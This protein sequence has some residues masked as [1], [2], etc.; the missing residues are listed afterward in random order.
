MSYVEFSE[1]DF[2]WFVH[3]IDAYNPITCYPYLNFLLFHIWSQWFTYIM[4]LRNPNANRAS[5]Y[6]YDYMYSYWNMYCNT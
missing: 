1:F 3:I 5:N 2:K 4:A 6:R